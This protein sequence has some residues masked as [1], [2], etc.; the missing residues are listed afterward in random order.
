MTTT[1]P[2]FDSLSRLPDGL[3][4]ERTVYVQFGHETVS[5]NGLLHEGLADGSADIVPE[6]LLTADA[7][8]ELEARYRG[9]AESASELADAACVRHNVPKKMHL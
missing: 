9:Y 8:R 4:G 3:T 5:F 1:V 7:V 2:A 6:G